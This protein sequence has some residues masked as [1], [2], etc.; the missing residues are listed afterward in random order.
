MY[1]FDFLFSDSLCGM[2]DVI[3]PEKNKDIIIIYVNTI[4]IIGGTFCMHTRT[5]SIAIE[6]AVIFAYSR[7][8]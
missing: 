3:S 1:I 2:F 5:S 7:F 8:L 4:H 6:D